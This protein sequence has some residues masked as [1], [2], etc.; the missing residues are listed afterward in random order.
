MRGV[1]DEAVVDG[2]WTRRLRPDV[3]GTEG[4]VTVRPAQPGK[5][6]VEARID[7]LKALPGVLARVRRVFDL[8]ADPEAI[9]RDLS[10]DP[11][12]ATAMAE[13]PGLRPP[14]DWIIDNRLADDRLEIQNPALVAR[15]E[16]WRPWR[17]YGALYWRRAMET[18]EAR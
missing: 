8:A 9:A 10:A 16:G 7:N 12:L 2:A 3:D 5:A 18:G 11:V 1:A 17:A 14:G 13:R 4:A 6:A 15:A